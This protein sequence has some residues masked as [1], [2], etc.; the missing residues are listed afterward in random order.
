M[1]ASLSKS[2]AP[3]VSE[4]QTRAGTWPGVEGPGFNPQH[5]EKKLPLGPWWSVGEGGQR[6]PAPPTV[7]TQGPGL[8]GGRSGLAPGETWAQDTQHLAP[9]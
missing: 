9:P 4:T 7:S 8:C 5:Q 1:E 6:P 3:S 2:E